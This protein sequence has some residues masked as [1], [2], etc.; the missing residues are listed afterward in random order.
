MESL[1][2]SDRTSRRTGLTRR[3]CR[4]GERRSGVFA[5]FNALNSM[6]TH[7]ADTVRAMHGLSLCSVHTHKNSA[8]REKA[9]VASLA[10]LSRL[11]FKFK[12]E[13]TQTI[14]LEREVEKLDF[15]L[16]ASYDLPNSRTPVAAHTALVRCVRTLEPK[17]I[18]SPVAV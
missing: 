4:Y 15:A 3:A 11:R 6:P 10:G 2:A 12:R 5:E 14:F 13:R 17:Q 8:R 7:C 9:G 18:I 1:L 16:N